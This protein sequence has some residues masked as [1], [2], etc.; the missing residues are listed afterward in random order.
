MKKLFL[1]SMLLLC[2]FYCTS[3]W[4]RLP[5][6]YVRYS[7]E[8]DN[9]KDF[10]DDLYYNK[11]GVDNPIFKDIEYK[12]RCIP[13]VDYKKYINCSQ[14]SALFDFFGFFVKG[15]YHDPANDDEF[16]D[17]QRITSHSIS[18]KVENYL[19]IT[20][21]KISFENDFSIDNLMEKEKF[22]ISKESI[23][24]SEKAVTSYEKKDDGEIYYYIIYRISYNYQ[25]S[26][27]HSTSAKPI[28]EF[29]FGVDVN[30][31][32][33]LS[34]FFNTYN[35][36]LKTLVVKKIFEDMY[37]DYLKKYNEF[38]DKLTA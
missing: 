1:M 8:Y 33:S 35:N 23:G 7:V 4:Y 31:R 16:F 38:Q 11:N 24:G 15:Q 6:E 30:S 9:Y 22:T 14:F 2:M 13:F 18:M 17:F 26:S 5:Y 25:E 10:L 37:N 21:L 20:D 12:N 29:K 34:S 28:I 3:C 19:K 27:V 36:H 32:E